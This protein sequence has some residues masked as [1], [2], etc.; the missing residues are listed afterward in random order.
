MVGDGVN[1]AP[2]LGQAQVSIAIGEGADLAKSA[3]DLVLATNSPGALAYAL[4]KA[5]QCRAVVRENLAWALVYNLLALPAAAAGWLNP[6][7]AA[8]G[9]SLSSLLVVGNAARLARDTKRA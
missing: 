6:W 9:M 8:L 3:A 7:L 2:S 1:D 5:R 4:Y